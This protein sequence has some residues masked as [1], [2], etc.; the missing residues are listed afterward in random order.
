MAKAEEIKRRVM[1]FVFG[2]SN[3]RKLKQ[4]TFGD[5]DNVVH[6]RYRS[7]TKRPFFSIYP[8]TLEADYD[9]WICGDSTKYYLLPQSTIKRIYHDPDTYRDN[10]HDQARVVS[11]DL[12]SHTMTYGAGGKSLDATQ[13][14]N[15]TIESDRQRNRNSED[16]ARIDL[17]TSTEWD[18]DFVWGREASDFN[19]PEETRKIVT[20]TT[21][22]IRDTSLSL[23]IKKLYDNCCQICDHALPMTGDETYAEAHH[24]RPL[25]SP[26]D[27]PDIRE[28]I[29]CVC[30][31]H[32]AQLDYGAIRLELSELSVA[33]AHGLGA[34][35][36]EYHNTEIY[37]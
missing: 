2:H 7:P 1:D 34:E 26:H 4:A 6:V 23:Q 17:V 8:S 16:N 20:L 10:T 21:R 12:E 32:H 27:G 29:I 22:I 28:N 33:P 37:G 11:V 24:I 13:F 15:G 25:G 18:Y 31:N 19:E 14:F 36:V 5:G 35:F 3:F 30:P 9:V